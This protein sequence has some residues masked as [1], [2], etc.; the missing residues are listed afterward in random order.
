MLKNKRN[1]ARF[2]RKRWLSMRDG[3]RGSPSGLREP[4]QTSLWGEPMQVRKS[5]SFAGCLAT[6]ALV[7]SMTAHA[8][9]VTNGG[10]ETGD[11]TGWTQFGNTAFSGV[12]SFAPQAGNF[13]SFFGPVGSPGGIFQTLATTPGSEYKVDFW[14]MNEADVIGNATPNSF[15]FNVNGGPDELTLTNSPATGYVHYTFGF[16]AT[17]AAT[18]L[19]FTFEHDPAFWDLDSVSAVVPEPGTLALLTLAGSLVGLTRRRRNV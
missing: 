17:G 6:V 18:D 3:E 19:R 1:E 9:L 16:V 2:V 14:L 12:D 7:A 8:V 5:Y 13:A 10:F 11:F 15:S 4:A